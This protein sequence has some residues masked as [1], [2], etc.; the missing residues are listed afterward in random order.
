MALGVPED[1]RVDVFHILQEA[2]LTGWLV[3][4]QQWL[5]FWLYHSSTAPQF[6]YLSSGN[7]V[8]V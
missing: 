1:T 5:S 3:A 2:L 6:P 8:I 7:N 4:S